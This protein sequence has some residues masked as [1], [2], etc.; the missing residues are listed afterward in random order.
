VPQ[1]GGVGAA[2]VKS[3]APPGYAKSRL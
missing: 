3:D 2:L 1:L